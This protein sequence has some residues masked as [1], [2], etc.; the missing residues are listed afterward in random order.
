[1]LMYL[2]MNKIMRILKLVILIILVLIP[3]QISALVIY[4][5]N[6]FFS[7][8]NADFQSYDASVFRE[9][10]ILRRDNSDDSYKLFYGELRFYLKEEYKNTI[11]HLDAS[12][13]SLWGADNFQGGDDGQNTFSFSK[14]YFGY[15]INENSQLK[16]GRHKYEI[17]NAH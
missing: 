6:Y 10:Q 4:F 3:L 9:N 14:L 15:A 12:R 7:F 17:G 2:T 1:M 16:L 8:E 11:F 13:F 5:N